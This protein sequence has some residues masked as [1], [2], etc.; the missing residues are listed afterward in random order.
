MSGLTPEEFG[1]GDLMTPN[2]DGTPEWYTVDADNVPQLVERI[3]AAA[4]EQ[5]RAEVVAPTLPF[6]L[7]MPTNREDNA[8][9]R[10]LNR[11]THYVDVQVILDPAMEPRGEC[12]N[13]YGG[14]VI[15]LREWDEQVFLHEVLHA[16]TGYS[17]PLIVTTHPPHGHEVISRVEVALWET[18]WRFRA[19]LATEPT[20]G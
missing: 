12:R 13:G 14:P 18:G 7:R 11:G 10:D 5:A 4:A 8:E 6:T 2:H 17:Q 16:A 20:D 9:G 1:L 15:A 3:K 19:A